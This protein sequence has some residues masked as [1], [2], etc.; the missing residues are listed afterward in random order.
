MIP[1]TL[2]EL[3]RYRPVSLQAGQLHSTSPGN[4]VQINFPDD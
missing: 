3:K 2:G 4:I 1:H